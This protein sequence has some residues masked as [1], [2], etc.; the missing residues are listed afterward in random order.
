ML[1]PQPAAK[2][3]CFS[4]TLL[5]HIPV[6][7]TSIKPQ[8]KR[9]KQASCRCSARRE[10]PC[11]TRAQQS[12]QPFTLSIT[13]QYQGHIPRSLRAHLGACPLYY[14]SDVPP[15]GNSSPDH[16]APSS[17]GTSSD[18]LCAASHCN[19]TGFSS[20]GENHY[21]SCPTPGTS[22]EVTA[23]SWQPQHRAGTAHS[24]ATWKWV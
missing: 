24:C 12:L 8:L 22:T 3:S 10:P 21:I 4:T 6:L 2:G 7:V 5:T 14:A 16:P 17:R 13:Q 1:C 11:S 20:P 18:K 19:T 23:S 9:V 15:H